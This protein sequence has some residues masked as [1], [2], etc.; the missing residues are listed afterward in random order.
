MELKQCVFVLCELY[1]LTFYLKGL[2]QNIHT[3]NLPLSIV[4]WTQMFW[5]FRFEQTTYIF[6]LF[7][8]NS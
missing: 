4:N 3:T 2:F 8:C 5:N 7:F 1:L 6:W